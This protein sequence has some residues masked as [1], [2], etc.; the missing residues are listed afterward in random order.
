MP[1]NGPP[2]IPRPR[3]APAMAPQTCCF[4]PDCRL[5][6]F[7]APLPD[8]NE[9]GTTGSQDVLIRKDYAVSN[10]S[11]RGPIHET[12]S[13]IPSWRSG[14]NRTAF[15][16]RPAESIGVETSHF[17]MQLANL[18]AVSKN[19]GTIFRQRWIQGAHCARVDTRPKKR[20]K[21]C[22]PPAPNLIDP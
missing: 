1:P 21:S 6:T 8:W 22:A 2:Q 4:P 5:S 14:R 12:L 11:S 19:R 15:M 20:R 13:K 3:W 9:D 17:G 18:A 10:T 7:L 16:R